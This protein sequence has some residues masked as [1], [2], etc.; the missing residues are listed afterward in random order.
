MKNNLNATERTLVEIIRAGNLVAD[1]P[2]RPLP[3]FADWPALLQAAAQHTV[4]N[5]LHVALSHSGALAGVPQDVR[6]RLRLS[7]VRALAQ[8]T[9]KLSV[10]AEIAGGMAARGVTVIALKGCALAPTLY[11]DAGLRFIGDIDFLMRREDIPL[12][13]EIALQL[14]FEA[15][16][17]VFEEST[18]D[19][20][21]GEMSFAR[22]GNPPMA[23]DAHWHIFNIPYFVR[24]VPVDWFWA[25]TTPAMIGGQPALVLNEE[26]LMLHLCSHYVL[27]HVAIPSLRW[28]FDIALLVARRRDMIDWPVV[29]AAAHRFDLLGV[30]QDMLAHVAEVWDVRLDP[31]QHAQVFGAKPSLREHIFSRALVIQPLRPIVDGWMSGGLSR[32]LHYWRDIFFPPEAYM[33]RRYGREVEGPMMF[34]YAR[35]LRNGFLRLLGMN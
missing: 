2:V 14:G 25:H 5:Q 30:L 4:I 29:V 32:R 13:A 24:R 1:A 12:V 3:E 18:R 17:Y 11:G 19:A 16:L 8:N 22:A 23:L 10:F 21:M 15:K 31:A 26:A 35:R 27:H 34:F 20:Q 33:R 7:Y 6:E 28:S 9:R